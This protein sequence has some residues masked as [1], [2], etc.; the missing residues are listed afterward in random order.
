MTQI[1]PSGAAPTTS[2]LAFMIIDLHYL[3]PNL[4][5]TRFLGLRRERI[6]LEERHNYMI[7]IADA[8][9]T[10]PSLG[11]S[12][13]SMRRRHSLHRIDLTYAKYISNVFEQRPIIGSQA[14][15][16]FQ[17]QLF[18]ILSL[19]DICHERCLRSRIP[20]QPGTK[21]VRYF[22]IEVKPSLHHSSPIERPTSPPFILPRQRAGGQR[23]DGPT[24]QRK[25]HLPSD[26]FQDN[27]EVEKSQYPMM[28][29][30]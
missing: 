24:I 28:V 26:K 4:E 7:E 5:I 1:F 14:Y 30:G 12:S 19:V 10:I 20:S 17:P 21:F 13:S 9:D 11:F 2:G 22:Q 27:T 15:T 16:I 6:F 29:R 18:P 3:F 23:A 8:L 25:Y